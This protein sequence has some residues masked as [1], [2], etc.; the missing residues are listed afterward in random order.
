MEVLHITPNKT[1]YTQPQPRD[2]IGLPRDKSTSIRIEVAIPSLVR[3]F[4]A[5]PD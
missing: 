3:G 4:V 2:L 5:K 1:G